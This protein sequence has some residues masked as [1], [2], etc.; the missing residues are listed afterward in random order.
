MQRALERNNSPFLPREPRNKLPK[1]GAS[2]W[3]VFETTLTKLRISACAWK[4]TTCVQSR[5]EVPRQNAEAS[6]YGYV[7]V[8]RYQVHNDSPKYPCL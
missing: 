2:Q 5:L 8:I 1:K 7:I 3:N 6:Q 4:P